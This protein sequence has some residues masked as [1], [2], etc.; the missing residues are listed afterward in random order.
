MKRD[1]QKR[2]NQVRKSSECNTTFNDT[3]QLHKHNIG[4]Y[5]ITIGIKIKRDIKGKA[6]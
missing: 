5:I 2:E 1:I 6:K 3:Y 4:V